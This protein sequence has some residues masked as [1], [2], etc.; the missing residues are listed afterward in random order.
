MSDDVWEVRCESNFWF[1]EGVCYET[2]KEANRVAR[3]LNLENLYN[4]AR[5]LT[6]HPAT[7]TKVGRVREV[8]RR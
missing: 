4:A 2:E 1:E 3:E 5:G 7:V 8:A 6:V